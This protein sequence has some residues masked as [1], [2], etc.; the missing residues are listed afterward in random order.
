MIRKIGAGVVPLS[1]D[2]AVTP[3]RTTDVLQK[4]DNSKS[5]R[6]A[7]IDTPESAVTQLGG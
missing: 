5:Y 3:K 4:P 7:G 6:H 1:P 2:L